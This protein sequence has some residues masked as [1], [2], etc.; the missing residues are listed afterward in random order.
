MIYKIHT[1]KMTRKIKFLTLATGGGEVYLS[2]PAATGER[3]QDTYDLPG[4]QGWK[5]KSNPSC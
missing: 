2:S 4:T 1:R 3:A 5:Q